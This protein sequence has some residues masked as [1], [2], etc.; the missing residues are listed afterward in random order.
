MS[1]SSH[2]A[3]FAHHAS[4]QKTT[5]AALV[6]GKPADLSKNTAPT[7]SQASK[8][9]PAIS[10]TTRLATDKMQQLQQPAPSPAP[11]VSTFIKR[12]AEDNLESILA[13][14]EPPHLRR[15]KIFNTLATNPT[16]TPKLKSKTISSPENLT[17]YELKECYDIARAAMSAQ[18]QHRKCNPAMME[19]FLKGVFEDWNA[20]EDPPILH[21]LKVF[22]FSNQGIP[23]KTVIGTMKVGKSQALTHDVELKLTQW[24]TGRLSTSSIGSLSVSTMKS[25]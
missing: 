1:T 24:K 2:F 10:T 17:D 3:Q 11:K 16:G 19:D 21:E 18:F 15:L 20:L 5:P 6:D 25:A 9:T 23:S 22:P 4:A 13:K 8:P 12:E 7:S 14:P